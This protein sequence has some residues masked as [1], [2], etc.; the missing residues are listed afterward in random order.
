MGYTLSELEE[1]RDGL[2]KRVQQETFIAKNSTSPRAKL[3][4]LK[5]QD[6][7]DNILRQIEQHPHRE[8]VS[9]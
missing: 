9:K 1:I 6:E 7:L 8:K 2:M 5:Y 3:V 4:V